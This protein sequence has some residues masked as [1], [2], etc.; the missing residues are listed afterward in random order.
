MAQDENWKAELTEFLRALTELA[1]LGAQA[2]KKELEE[3]NGEGKK[4]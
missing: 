3:K 2:L 4:A 1:K